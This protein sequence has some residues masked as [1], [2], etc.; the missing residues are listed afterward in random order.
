[1]ILLQL[2]RW[3]EGFDE[4]AYCEM[5]SPLFMRPQWA[6]AMARGLKPWCGEDIAGKK[7]LLIHDHGFGDTIM[8]LR[9]V[10]QLKGR[11]ADVVLQMPPELERLAAQVAPVTRELVDADYVCSILLLMAQLDGK[12]IWDTPYLKVDARLAR[13]VA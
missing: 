1:M 6:A 8:M 12:I 4:F 11:G 7:L 3:Q 10:P 13:Q 9:F 5:T 2:G